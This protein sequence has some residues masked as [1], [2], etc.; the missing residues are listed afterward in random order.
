MS[1]H[2]HDQ[3]TKGPFVGDTGIFQS[4]L[5][6]HS[7]YSSG[8]RNPGGR[9]R[10]IPP[11]QSPRNCNEDQDTLAWLEPGSPL[12]KAWHSGAGFSRQTLSGS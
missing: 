10:H 8:P 7:Q 6:L 11:L 1:V 5:S 4:L 12:D 9:D 3:V 2:G